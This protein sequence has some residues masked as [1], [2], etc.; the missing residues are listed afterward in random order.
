MLGAQLNGEVAGLAGQ[1]ELAG[2]AEAAQ[3]EGECFSQIDQTG[4]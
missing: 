4:Q 2:G 3:A 1:G